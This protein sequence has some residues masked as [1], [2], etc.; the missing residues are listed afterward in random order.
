MTNKEREGE[1]D[2][3][4]ALKASLAVRA[5]R[6]EGAIMATEVTGEVMKSVFPFEHIE[7]TLRRLRGSEKTNSLLEDLQDI[8]KTMLKVPLPNIDSY[9]A[10]CVGPNNNPHG[11]QLFRPREGS[12]YISAQFLKTGSFEFAFEGDYVF[13]NTIIS[14]AGLKKFF[15]LP[16]IH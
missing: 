3:V 16:T 14:I 11:I 9:H 12:A 15:R 6:K 2:I 10:N 1:E 8:I 5:E 4:E 7:E 13:K